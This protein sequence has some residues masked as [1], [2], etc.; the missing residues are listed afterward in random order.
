MTATTPDPAAAIRRA[1]PEDAAALAALRWEFRSAIGKVN[2]AGDAF[3]ARCGEWMRARLGRGGAWRAWVAEAGGE[4]V[5]TVWVQLV[6][7][8]PNPVD[9][10]EVH[11]YLTNLFVRDS[12]RGGGTGGRLLAAALEEC[13]AAGVHTVFLWPTQRSRPLYRRFGFVGDGD[14]MLWSSPRPAT[15]KETSI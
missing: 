10:A 7:K 4:I 8:M 12:L 1:A 13:A 5:G 3:V 15:G 2:E 14:V 11:G 6:E 9:E